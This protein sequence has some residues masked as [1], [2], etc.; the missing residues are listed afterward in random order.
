MYHPLETTCITV[1]DV[2]SHV[3][4]ER[5]SQYLRVN[6]ICATF[7]KDRV[8]CTACPLLK[9]V[10]QLW[11]GDGNKSV[12]V[13]VQRRQGCSIHMRRVRRGL[14]RAIQSNSL[15]HAPDVAAERS[16]SQQLKELMDAAMEEC[17][18]KQQVNYNDRCRERCKDAFRIANGLMES[19][20]LDQNRLG[21]ESLEVLTN[22]SIVKEEDALFLSKMLLTCSGD[23]ATPDS[24]LLRGSFVRYFQGI[25]QSRDSRSYPNNEYDSDDDDD[26]NFQNYAKGRYFGALHSV[27]LRALG[28]ALSVL[29][30][31]HDKQDLSLDFGS[32]YWKNIVE[33]L[34]YNVEVAKDRPQEA[35]L[36]VRCISLLVTL[37]PTF[38]RAAIVEDRLVPCLVQAN[39]FGKAHH[40]ILE[41]ESRNLMYRMANVR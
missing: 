18:Q 22:P 10:V 30:D 8:D 3:I 33:S 20:S 32:Y 11:Q 1:K 34:V 35:A 13:E 28:N 41:N 2:P 25:E 29:A 7:H 24:E 6:S 31:N 9:F 40:L 23:G 36:S 27:A 39:Q 37:S 26:D 5:I 4:S 19:S 38:Q 15:V 21:M 12:L 16:P 17:S 14:F